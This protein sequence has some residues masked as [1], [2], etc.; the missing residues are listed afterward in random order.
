MRA[1]MDRKFIGCLQTEAALLG[2]I[3][4]SPAHAERA[5][6]HMVDDDFTSPQH[7][8][9]FRTI[10]KLT[11]D[12][13]PADPITVLGELRRAGHMR[14]FT[15]HKTAGTFLADLVSACP[16]PASAG[17][18]AQTLIEH[19]VRRQAAASA[20]RIE[21]AAGEMDLQELQ[22]FVVVE[23]EAVRDS[24]NRTLPWHPYLSQV[25]A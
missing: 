23:L 24:I 2:A 25:V 4:A 11:A 10:A 8:L 13:I 3:L 22:R 21:Q 14:S 5:V 15:C 9:V 6:M 19:T 7:A 12:G 20:E 1:G 18:Y 17:H 16:L